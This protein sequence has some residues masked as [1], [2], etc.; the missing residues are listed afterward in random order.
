MGES[1][2]GELLNNQMV[3]RVFLMGKSS[4]NGEFFSIAMFKYR[5]GG[6]P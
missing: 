2:H 5:I 1:F 3:Y 4:L 6:A